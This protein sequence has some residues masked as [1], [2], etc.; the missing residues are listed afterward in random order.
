MLVGDPQM[1]DNKSYKANALFMIASKF[2]SDLYMK[3]NYKYLT[4]F[5]SPS[6][7]I[8]TGDLMDN[9]REWEDDAL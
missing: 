6:D 1:T 4:R 8:I 2:Y 7:I 3:R 9:G 5:I